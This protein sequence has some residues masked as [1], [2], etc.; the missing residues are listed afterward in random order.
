MK[1][2]LIVAII[3]IIIIIGTFIY[4]GKTNAPSPSDTNTPVDTTPTA[5]TG[6][7]GC[8]AMRTGQDVF[9]LRVEHQE[10]LNVAGTLAFKNFEKDSSSGTFVGTYNNDILVGDYTFNSEG[11]KSVM[12]VAF[13]KVG[14]DFV[15][16]YGDVDSTGTKFVDMTKITYDTSSPLAVFKAESCI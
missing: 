10:G 5:S 9:T 11:M 4:A 12:Q 13:K 3:A 16:G 7:E 15:R 2:S 1:P 14:N 8:Y 6:I